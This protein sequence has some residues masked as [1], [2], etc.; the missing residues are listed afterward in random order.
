MAVAD[1]QELVV[2]VFLVRSRDRTA[3]SYPSDDGERHIRERHCEDEQ[4]D[5]HGDGQRG[6]LGIGGLDSPTHSGDRGRAENEAQEHAS[7]VAHEDAR[8]VEVVR[9]EPHRGP[10]HHHRE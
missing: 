9:E 4:W 6:Q 7:G 5:G 10:R 2:D 3:S 8:R 1:L